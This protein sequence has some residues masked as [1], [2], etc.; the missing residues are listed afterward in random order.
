[1]VITVLVIAFAT[2]FMLRSL[3]LQYGFVLNEFD[4]Y[5]DF[6]A[7]NFLIENGMFEYFTWHDTMSWYP[8][9]RDIAA[10]SQTGLHLV[11]AFLYKAFAFGMPLYDFVVWFP[12]IFGSFTAII[13]FALVRV[14]S[15]TSAGYSQ[16]FSSQFHLQSSNVETLDGSNQSLWDYSLLYLQSISC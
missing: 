9:G 3:P 16:L 14:I 12:V 6:R 2:S 13:I 11:T 8:E 10:T 5:F 4:P 15:S 7:T 1:M